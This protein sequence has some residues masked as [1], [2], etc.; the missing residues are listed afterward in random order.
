MLAAGTAEPGREA[1]LCEAAGRAEE[2]EGGVAPAR[3]RGPGM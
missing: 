1:P 2:G 3:Q